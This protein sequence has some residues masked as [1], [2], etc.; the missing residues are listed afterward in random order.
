MRTWV[1][2]PCMRI[3]ITLVILAKKCLRTREQQVTKVAVFSRIRIVC[4]W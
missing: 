2:E 4:S 3:S 1:R